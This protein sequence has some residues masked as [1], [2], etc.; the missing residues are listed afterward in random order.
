MYCQNNKSNHTKIVASIKT[1][2]IL[3]AAFG[4]FAH[5]K[6]PIRPYVLEGTEFHSILSKI[7]K[8]D[9]ENFVSLPDSYSKG[10]KSYP[11]L[12]I[13]DANYA[14]PVVRSINRCGSD[15]GKSLQEFI[16]IAL[17]YSRGDS[18]VKCRYREYTPTDID[19]KKTRDADQGGDEYGDA[20]KY[21]RYLNEEVFSYVAKTFRAD[22]TRKVFMGHSYGSLFGTYVLLTE[23]AMF[24]HYVLSSPSLWFD[25]YAMLDAERKYARMRKELRAAVLL[26]AGSYEAVKPGSKNKR[27]NARA[28]MVLDTTA[29]EK[30]L[31]ARRYPGLT[32]RSEEIA[33][34]GHLTVAPAAMTRGLIWAFGVAGK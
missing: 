28:D 34:E 14:F 17:S 4:T 13:T 3:L 9:Y 24:S 29:F 21:R 10:V 2:T 6:A 23:P 5:G 7:L 20:E 26:M 33:D 31:K 18:T 27:F 8:R 22:I 1:I 30:Q 15:N 25:K 32:I 12:F 19:A 11:V 16:L